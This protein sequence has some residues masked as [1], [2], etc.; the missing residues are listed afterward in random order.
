M[1]VTRTRGRTALKKKLHITVFSLL[2]GIRRIGV[3]SSRGGSLV[4]K[5]LRPQVKL[6]FLLY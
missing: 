3:L 2:R 4:A 1:V 6:V 5:V